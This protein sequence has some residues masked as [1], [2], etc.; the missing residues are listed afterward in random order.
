LPVSF[1]ATELAFDTSSAAVQFLYANNAGFFLKPNTKSKNGTPSDPSE[2]A[3][4]DTLGGG[5]SSLLN[6]LGK[7]STDMEVEV[8]DDDKILDC[9][10]AQPSLV[11]CLTTKHSRVGIKGRI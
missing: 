6:R 2:T 11:E 8:D 3:G 1:I 7:L 9:R 4:G 10:A 5:S